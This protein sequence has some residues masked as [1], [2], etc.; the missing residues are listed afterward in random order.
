MLGLT[1]ISK[2]SINI[3]IVADEIP[4]SSD[5]H[6]ILDNTQGIWTKGDSLEYQ[7]VLIWDV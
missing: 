5:F 1:P 4:T 7:Q 2:L 6:T 3:S